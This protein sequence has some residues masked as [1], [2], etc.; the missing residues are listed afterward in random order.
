MIKKINLDKTHRLK[1]INKLALLF[2]DTKL[3]SLSKIRKIGKTIEILSDDLIL[4]SL[5]SAIND[6]KNGRYTTLTKLSKEKK[7]EKKKTI[8]K[9]RN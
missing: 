7:N 4:R 6:F 5:N 9:K 3:K 1:E 8:I 2:Q